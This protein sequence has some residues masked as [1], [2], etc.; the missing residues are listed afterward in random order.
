MSVRWPCRR[1]AGAQASLCEH[2][3]DVEL[4]LRETDVIIVRIAAMGHLV[5]HPA[6]FREEAELRREM[7]RAAKQETAI[8]TEPGSGTAGQLG[9]EQL[10]RQTGR[11]PGPHLEV[12]RLGSDGNAPADVEIDVDVIAA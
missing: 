11:P 1:E 4:P 9:A 6:D 8:P 10:E 7:N 2:E 12:G 5:L 3:A